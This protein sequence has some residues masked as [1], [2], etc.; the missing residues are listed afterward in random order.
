MTPGLVAAALSIGK[1][2]IE[3][4]DK[5]A[6]LAY[7]TMDKLLASRT[8]R[9][10]DA[11][12]KL[13]FAAEQITKGLVRPL[14]SCGMFVYGVLNP[15]VLQQMHAL[16]AAGDLGIAAMMGSAPAWGYSRH[17]EKQKKPQ[18]SDDF[19]DYND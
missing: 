11:V 7:Q 4:K 9:L 19:I 16:G 6:D 5:K 17:K 2:L 1:E 3:D 12:V 13:A 10:V 8:Y 18:K 14:V 15:D